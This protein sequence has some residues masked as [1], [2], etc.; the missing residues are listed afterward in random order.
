MD[1]DSDNIDPCINEAIATIAIIRTVSCFDNGRVNSKS[2][3]ASLYT[4]PILTFDCNG[5]MLTL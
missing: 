3:I 4:V 5:L 2:A 1:P